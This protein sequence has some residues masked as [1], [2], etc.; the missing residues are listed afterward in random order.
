[1]EKVLRMRSKNLKRE[2]EKENNLLLPF[3]AY[4]LFKTKMKKE[5]K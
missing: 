4:L 1:M 2:R 5:L 3:D